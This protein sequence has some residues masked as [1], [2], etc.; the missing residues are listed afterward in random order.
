MF[1]ELV[2]F[3]AKNLVKVTLVNWIG[4]CGQSMLHIYIKFSGLNYC[5]H[6]LQHWESDYHSR[7]PNCV[8]WRKCITSSMKSMEEEL[9]TSSSSSSSSLENACLPCTAVRHA[10]NIEL[11]VC[12][13]YNITKVC[14]PLCSDSGVSGQFCSY[15]LFIQTTEA[16]LLI[17][18]EYYSCLEHS[19]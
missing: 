10:A 11:S 4:S 14:I 5:P 19:H 1:W 15:R 8:L 16:W 12:C 7:L 6:M 3:L 9:A 18:F 17:L 13:E 2:H